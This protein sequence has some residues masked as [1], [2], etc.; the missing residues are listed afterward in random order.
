MQI[1]KF[2]K[3]TIIFFSVIVIISG[4][5]VNKIF[6]KKEALSFTV[7]AVSKGSLMQ[8]ISESGVVKKGQNLTL[9][10][11]QAGRIDS[12]LAKVGQTVSAGQILARLDADQ[13][14][15]QISEAKAN[16]QAAQVQNQSTQTAE[17]NA[18]TALQT[19]RQ[20]LNDITALA[21]V[22][23]A[24]AYQD[25][26]IESENGYL[27][28]YSALDVVK[29]IKD[30]YFIYSD[31]E[32]SEATEA[33]NLIADA[34]SKIKF[35]LDG[36]KTDPS[37]QNID[38]LLGIALN[39][40]KDTFSAL[41]TVRQAANSPVYKNTVSSSYKASLDAQRTGIND[42]QSAV[43]NAKQAIAAVKAENDSNINSAQ[44]QILQAEGKIT[45]A[46]NDINLYAARTV[47]AQASLDLL[48]NKMRDS[49]ISAALAGTITAINKKEG[50]T[51]QP[52]EAIF[53]FLTSGSTEIKTDIYEE[54]VVKVKVGDETDIRVTAFPG[55][56]FSGKVLTI[57]P[58][59]KL[60]DGVVYYEVTI[61]FNDAPQEIR[62]GMSADITIK[63]ASRN[64]VLVIPGSAVE[65]NKDGEFF[66]NIT[67]GKEIIAEREVEIGLRGSNNLAEILS[68]ILEGERIAVPK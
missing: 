8:E 15:I 20:N 56:I 65:K 61:G 32:G 43:S 63:T 10:F 13:L 49:S 57:D 54:D 39:S 12:I 9:S 62:P 18:Q 21:S 26:L 67:D 24:N 4:L 30:L 11:K 37:N 41:T 40:L 53:S 50:E 29:N 35:S 59:E 60:I 19:A 46:K 42:S 28:I 36:A 5:V 2:S 34:L 31:Q 48:E 7:E 27:E 58:A 38:N 66:V 55:Q 6:F 1:L 3:N 47:Q 45:E 22:N 68:G 14:S 64:D 52:S 17:A 25:A 16:L 51:V 23:L 44:N 33:R